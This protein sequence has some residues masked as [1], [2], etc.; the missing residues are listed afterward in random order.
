MMFPKVNYAHSKYFL[1]VNI[2]SDSWGLA[3]IVIGSFT[4]TAVIHFILESLLSCYVLHLMHNG[5]SIN[6]HKHIVKETSLRVYLPYS[7]LVAGHGAESAP[8]S[9]AAVEQ[10]TTPT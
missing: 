3:F 4:L 1:C 6:A 2:V 10:L 7:L 5:I 8:L 9:A